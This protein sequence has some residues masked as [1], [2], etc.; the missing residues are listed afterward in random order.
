VPPKGSFRS[1]AID[2]LIARIKVKINKNKSKNSKC[3]KT[4]NNK[5]SI[6]GFDVLKKN[7]HQKIGNEKWILYNRNNPKHR[8]S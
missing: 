3:A 1:N 8:K 7:F 2:L 4:T 5:D 6:H